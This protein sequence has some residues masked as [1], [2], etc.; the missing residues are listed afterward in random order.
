[1]GHVP[2]RGVGAVSKSP[3]ALTAEN[4]AEVGN[5]STAMV[6]SAVLVG[7]CCKTRLLPGDFHDDR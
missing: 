1:M 5:L 3:A 2:R 6:N 7:L 4:L